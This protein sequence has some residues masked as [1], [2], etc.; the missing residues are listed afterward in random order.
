MHNIAS[1]EGKKTALKYLS[2][3]VSFTK[4]KENNV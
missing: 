4:L 3:T 1:I 2:T